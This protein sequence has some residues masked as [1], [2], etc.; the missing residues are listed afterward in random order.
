MTEMFGP[1]PDNAEVIAALQRSSGI[2]ALS[3]NLTN[4]ANFGS[5]NTN[6]PPNPKASDATKVRPSSNFLKLPA[7][8]RRGEVSADDGGV[9]AEIADDEPADY[10][11]NDE[12][13]EFTNTNQG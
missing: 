12:V 6:P 4:L 13:D 9:I 2:G 1:R 10:D 7:S 8:E 11:D 3:Q 5:S